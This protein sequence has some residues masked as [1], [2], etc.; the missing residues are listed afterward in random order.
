MEHI[1]ITPLSDGYVRLTPDEGYELRNKISG[2]LYSEVVTKDES[3]N[4][5]EAVKI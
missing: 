5:Y 4:D 2:R 3:K 1:T